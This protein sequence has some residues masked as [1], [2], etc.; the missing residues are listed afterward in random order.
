MSSFILKTSISPEEILGI[1]REQ[2]APL[3]LTSRF[4]I[5]RPKTC[6]VFSRISGNSFVLE[7]SADSFSKRLVATLIPVADGTEIQCHWTRKFWQKLYGHAHFDENAILGFLHDW[8]TIVQLP[9]PS[10]HD[11]IHTRV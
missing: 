3:A 7:S 6:P 11:N 5:F 2:T 1:L 8:L 9:L 10:S 4:N